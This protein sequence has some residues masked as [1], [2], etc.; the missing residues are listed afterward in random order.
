MTQR[1]TELKGL[2]NSL[3]CPSY[4]TCLRKKTKAIHQEVHSDHSCVVHADDG[5]SDHKG[6]LERIYSE[7]PIP[8]FLGLYESSFQ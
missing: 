5:K 8:G 4:S 3:F 2:E 1:E 6:Y 7:T